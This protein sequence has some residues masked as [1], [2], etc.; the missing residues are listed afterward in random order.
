MINCSDDCWQT[1]ANLLYL[2]VLS[3]THWRLEGDET[4][5]TAC[6]AREDVE[7]LSVKR[8]DEA[9]TQHFARCLAVGLVAV[10]LP[11]HA[12]RAAQYHACG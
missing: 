3:C 11:V 8:L 7:G 4:E 6:V 2:C 1:A 12:A 10:P 9:V 5:G